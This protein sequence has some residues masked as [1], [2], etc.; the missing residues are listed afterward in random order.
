MWSV[1]NCLMKV[2]KPKA[3]KQAS[4]LCQVD[5]WCLFSQ[6]LSPTTA[7]SND[8]ST[9]YGTS[10][11]PSQFSFSLSSF[12][13]WLLDL[14]S[15]WHCQ[16]PSW[17]ESWDRLTQHWFPWCNI[18][19]WW[20]TKMPQ[21]MWRFESGGSV[22]WREDGKTRPLPVF[23]H[24]ACWSEATFGF[25]HLKIH[26]TS[27][28]QGWCPAQQPWEWSRGWRGLILVDPASASSRF[29]IYITKFKFQLCQCFIIFSR[30]HFHLGLS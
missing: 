26:W 28:R 15:W 6:L 30:F 17:D 16:I 23:S 24:C 4:H 29:E 27:P 21:L 3:H 5:P 10:Q 18:G 19:V 8:A 14:E 22:I 7:R 20:S 1:L 12:Q 25:P 13:T 2:N 9:L 11:K